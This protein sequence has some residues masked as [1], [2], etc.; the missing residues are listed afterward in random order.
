MIIGVGGVG[1]GSGEMVVGGGVGCVRILEGD[2][3]EW[4]NVE[5]EEL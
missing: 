2:Y 4:R 5:R 3:I 1:R